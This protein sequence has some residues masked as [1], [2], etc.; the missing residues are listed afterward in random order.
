MKPAFQPGQSLEKTPN[1]AS[2][3]C[4]NFD[5]SLPTVL[6]VY[7]GSNHYDVVVGA[8]TAMW[9]EWSC[10]SPEIQVL[11]GALKWSFA[12]KPSRPPAAVAGHCQNC[13]GQSKTH[14]TCQVR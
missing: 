5:E 3:E 11:T 7:T 14:T 6:G 13:K 9:T 12:E 10:L 1:T 8:N 4:P 2:L